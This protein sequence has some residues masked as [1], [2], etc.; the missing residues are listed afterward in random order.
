MFRHRIRLT[1]VG[2][3]LITALS[4]CG[5][6]VTP[7]IA[8]GRIEAEAP[9]YK[10]G[11]ASGKMRLVHTHSSD[12]MPMVYVFAGAD[13]FAVAPADDAA[14]ALLGYGT[15]FDPDNIP[16]NM[17]WWLGEYA[18]QIEWLKSNPSPISENAPDDHPAIEALVTSNWGQDFPFNLL[19][20]QTSGGRSVTGCVATALAQIVNYHQWPQGPG[21]GTHSYVW[22]DQTLSFD[23][24]ATTFDWSLIKDRYP[25]YET[26]DEE[27]QEVAKLML[28]C[29]IGTDMGYSA[30]ASGAYDFNVP[31]LLTRHL[32]YDAGIKYLRRD[33]YSAS[34][35]DSI[36]Y[37]ELAAGRPV[38]YCG[39]TGSVGHAFV[40]DGYSS[41]GYYH[42]NWGWNGMS[43]GF[44]L[45]SALNPLEEGIGGSDSGYGYNQ[46]QCAVT[47]IRPA[48]GTTPERFIP[49]YAFGPMIWNA[50]E[51]Y[52]TFDD[53]YNGIYNYSGEDL[54][55]EL[56]VRLEDISGE[57]HYAGEG[58]TVTIPGFSEGLIHGEDGIRPVYPAE[59]P[60]GMYTA[61]PVVRNPGSGT[62]Q[63]IFIP[64]GKSGTVFV[65]KEEDGTVTVGKKETQNYSFL[66]LVGSVNGWDIENIIYRLRRKTDENRNTVYEGTVNL[67][68]GL[69]EFK[70]GT[71]RM[72]WDYIYGAF[73]TNPVSTLFTDDD[74]TSAKSSETMA[75]ISGGNNMALPQAWPGGKMTIRVSL[76]E[77]TAQFSWESEGLSAL[78]IIEAEGDGPVD[79]YNLQGMPVRKGVM[80][81]EATQGLPAGIYI[82]NG[83][84]ILVK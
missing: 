1:V 51:G 61:H 40:C 9:Q 17:Q 23:Y 74:F 60:A 43:D 64:Y 7:E 81:D 75:I 31:R 6:P 36:I 18:Q 80:T 63:Q 8:L 34:G 58:E 29:G 78:G 22:N 59:L 73:S 16:D 55:V 70:F 38:L 53:T 44:F 25:Y 13:G 27:R 35:W 47:G 24:G 50:D 20:P 79:V 3:A 83:K 21:T 30:K 26:T 54:D 56:G 45:L 49:L 28:A 33:Y 46:S 72:T 19:C 57:S 84:K 10:P 39:S 62:W 12:A 41:G 14:P 71:S 15:S 11:K 32:G 2:T 48:D 69:N 52:F 77:H 4:V 66:T 42:I 67:P 65:T 76:D 68:G 5:A 37:G 82:V